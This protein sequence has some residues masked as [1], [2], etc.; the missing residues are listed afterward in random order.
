MNNKELPTP[1]NFEQLQEFIEKIEK[2]K[3][4]EDLFKFTALHEIGHT[5][6]KALVPGKVD[7]ILDEILANDYALDWAKKYKVKMSPLVLDFIENAYK[8]HHVEKSIGKTPE[9]IIKVFK[10]MRFVK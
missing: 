9:S 8:P 5:L 4:L 7:H 3:Q 2:T 10:N 6:R 1:E